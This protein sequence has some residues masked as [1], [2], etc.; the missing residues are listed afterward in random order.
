M[1]QDVIK[2]DKVESLESTWNL[3]AYCQRNHR[4]VPPCDNHLPSGKL[5]GCYGKSPFLMGKLTINGKFYLRLVG[6]QTLP[7]KNISI[8]RSRL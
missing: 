7:M 3:A 8:S 6:A 5:T 4:Q 2:M 1:E